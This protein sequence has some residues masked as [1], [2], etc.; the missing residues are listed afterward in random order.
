MPLYSYECDCGRQ[1]EAVLPVKKCD[2]PQH[3]PDCGLYAKKV[4]KIGHGGIFRTG[5]SVPWVRDVAK[6][7]GDGE[8]PNP[9]INTVQDLRRYYKEHPN[10]LPKESHPAFPSSYGDALSKPDIKA[11]KERRSKI[12]HEKL[13]ELRTITVG[14][15]TA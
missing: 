15:A 8:K 4:I 3:C 2:Y 5:D 13:R 7:L 10:C 9:N 11:Q 14:Q 6:V 12:G 1:F